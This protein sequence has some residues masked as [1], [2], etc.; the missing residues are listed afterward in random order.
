M[1]PF[2]LQSRSKLLSVATRRVADDP[3]QRQYGKRDG[4]GFSAKALSKK[5]ASTAKVNDE[6]IVAGLSKEGFI[7]RLYKQR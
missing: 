3:Q 6:S 7:D 4:M 1:S 5:P 2:A